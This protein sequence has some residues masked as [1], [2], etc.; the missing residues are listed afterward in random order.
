MVTRTPPAFTSFTQDVDAP[1]LLPADVRVTGYEVDRVVSVI[2]SGAPEVSAGR[3]LWRLEAPGRL[4]LPEAP[5]IGATTHAVYTDSTTRAELAQISR[6]ES[7]PVAVLIPLRKS[8]EW[9]ALGREQRQAYV[10]EG[11]PN[12]HVA[13]GRRYADRIYRRLYQARYLPGSEW[14]FLTYFEF[15]RSLVQTFGELLSTLRDVRVNPE[16][17]FV[18]REAEIWM[19]RL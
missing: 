19:M 2:G 13:I 7:G 10:M 8:A 5:F 15:P 12:G 3:R 6:G 4:P 16:W 14:D 1:A 9:W 17:G 11:A 18:D